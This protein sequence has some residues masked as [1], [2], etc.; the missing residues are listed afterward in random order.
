MENMHGVPHSQE[1]HASFITIEVTAGH[2]QTHQPTNT[3]VF[4][5]LSYICHCL[6]EVQ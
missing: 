1:Y 4:Q 5:S 6:T 2:S 3:N